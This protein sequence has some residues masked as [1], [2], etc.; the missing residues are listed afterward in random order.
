MEKSD[1]KKSLLSGVFAGAR[2]YAAEFIGAMG[3]E[4]RTA[5]IILDKFGGLIP[6]VGP[7]AGKALGRLCNHASDG[8]GSLTDKVR[9]GY[10]IEDLPRAAQFLPRWYRMIGTGLSKLNAYATPDAIDT[11]VGK[12]ESVR[13]DIIKVAPKAKLP[14]L[15]PVLGTNTP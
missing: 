7:I 3:H 4:T 12:Y 8:L 6:E 13:D 14:T 11:L 9:G 1:Q 5:G 15:K 10:Q 2:V